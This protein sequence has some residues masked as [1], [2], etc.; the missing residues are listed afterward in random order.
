MNK[1]L[2]K[3]ECPAFLEQREPVTNAESS[4]T[5]FVEPHVLSGVAHSAY[6]TDAGSE[7]FVLAEIVT[8]IVYASHSFA[9]KERTSTSQNLV[10]WRCHWAESVWG[11]KTA[12]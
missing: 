5:Q 2:L 9:R 10:G 7:A 12:W 3:G 1:I 8:T 11:S 6:R 4:A